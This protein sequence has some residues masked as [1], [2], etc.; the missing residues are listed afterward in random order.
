MLLS[1]S[2]YCREDQ[3]INYHNKKNERGD[4]PHEIGPKKPDTSYNFRSF[5]SSG[6]TKLFI[7]FKQVKVTPI[8]Y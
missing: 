1:I 5:L 2:C 4:V 8:K 3:A 7:S 6:V